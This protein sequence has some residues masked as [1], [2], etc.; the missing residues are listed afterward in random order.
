MLLFIC[1]CD[2]NLYFFFNIIKYMIPESFEYKPEV[3]YLNKDFPLYSLHEAQY[4]GKPTYFK[5]FVFEEIE[6]S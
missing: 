3:L 6:K 1:S 5:A 2:L 4:R